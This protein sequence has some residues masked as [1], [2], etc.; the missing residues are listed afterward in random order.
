MAEA[1]GQEKT[2][3]ATSKKLSDTRAK[4]QVARSIEINS[5]AVFTA[6]F[7]LVYLTQKYLGENIRHMTVSVFSDLDKLTLE[8]DQIAD[9][10]YRGISFFILTLGP[11]LGGLVLVSIIASYGQTGFRFSAK[12]LAPKF[13][14]FNPLSNI[15]GIFFSSRSLVEVGK[16]ILKLVIIGA[17][18]YWVLQDFI[19]TAIGLVNYQIDDLVTFM[20]EAAYTL[21]W[22]ISL[23]F[24][25]IAAA[26]FAFQKYKFRQ[27]LM[28]TKQEVKEEMRESD[29]NPEIK[30]KIRSIQM[31]QARARMMK[32]L[33][34]ADVV[35]TNPT[36]FAVALKYDLGKDSAPK[37]I[38]KGMDEL[39][40]RIK[41][42]ATENGVP[43][44]ENVALARA[45]Y[46]SC[47]V[48]D[49]IPAELFK[50][51]AQILAYI[52]KVK[53]EKKKK[54]IV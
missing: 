3:Q 16:S 47:E 12:A 25:I 48:G 5:F 34:K 54:S 23:C 37:V 10:A 9:Y 45:L 29:G 36:H 15:K 43:L 42:V 22:K 14:K 11:I 33:P 38:A 2:E 31:K 20:V 18:T 8:K 7:L 4:G 51:V 1:D 32:E 30:S 6:G 49:E 44:H 24:A 46:K 28:M 50:A 27:D 19:L 26:D 13:S 53:N 35:I 41:K 52:F 39:A 40:Q 17:F 21:L